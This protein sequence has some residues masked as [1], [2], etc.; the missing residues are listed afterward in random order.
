MDEKKNELKTIKVL[1][2][3]LIITTA[4]TAG[5]AAY[6]TTQLTST[7]GK[8]SSAA[9]EYTAIAA[10]NAVYDEAGK[11]LTYSELRGVFLT[12]DGEE[13]DG[14]TYDAKKNEISW[15]DDFDEAYD[16]AGNALTYDEET[17]GYLNEAGEEYKGIVLDA[18]GNIIG[19]T[20]E[21]ETDGTTE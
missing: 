2:I 5:L 20:S 10:A 14:K 12:K 9:E 17:G 16:E 8:L 11:P 13:Y 18:D 4:V 7:L 3:V 15:G 1:L 19:D 21:E 6:L